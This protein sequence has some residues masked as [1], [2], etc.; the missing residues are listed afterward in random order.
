MP[1]TKSVLKLVL[2]V[3]IFPEQEITVELDFILDCLFK[4][5]K[6]AV[7]LKCYLVIYIYII[8]IRPQ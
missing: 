7:S 4:Y 1:E 8:F 5:G 2:F 3:K 6:D